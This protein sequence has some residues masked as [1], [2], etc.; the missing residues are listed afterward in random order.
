M[1]TRSRRSRGSRS[2]RTVDAAVVVIGAGMA[3]LAAA[4]ELSEHGVS[5]IVLEARDRIGGRVHTLREAGV[6]LPIEVGPEFVHGE[7]PE[8][9]RIARAT[10]LSLIEVDATHWER[11]RGRVGQSQDF[12]RALGRSLKSAARHVRSGRDLTFSEAVARAR[13]REPAR[14]R[15]VDYVQGFQAAHADLVSTR[16]VTGEDLG[17]ER[18]RRVL[19]GCDQLA[20][21]WSARLPA[22]T[23][24]LDTI[25]ARVSWGEAGVDVACRSAFHGRESPARQATARERI[26][27]ADHAVVTLPLGVLAPHDGSDPPV[28]FDPPLHAKTRALSKLAMGNVVRIV[29]RFDA[30]FWEERS[31]VRAQ[32]DACLE[33]LSFLHPK[34]LPFQALWT[35]HPVHANLLTAWAGGTR[36]DA[37]AGTSE[38][39]LVASALR[40]IASFLGVEPALVR[41]HWIEAWHHDWRTDPFARGAYSYVLA[42]GMH[43]AHALAAPLD[44]KLH[45]AGEATCAPPAHGTLD[46]A[47]ASGRRAAREVLRFMAR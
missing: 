34:G 15:V 38:K 7:A 41:K 5:V 23:V 44:E 8:L 35:Q 11:R 43:A 24:K 17:T 21:R 26:V 29:L 42:G 30:P 14:T 19:E 27:H 28:L 10:G 46:G 4:V 25:V 32:K 6:G 9:T 39:D 3:G 47:V 36:A 2:K 37:L 1:T 12:E 31:L 18:I 22:G 40:S 13:L 20:E 45:F 33:R 16:S